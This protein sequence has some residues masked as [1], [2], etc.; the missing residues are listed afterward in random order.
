[1]MLDVNQLIYLFF[2]LA[3][4]YGWFILVSPEKPIIYATHFT[5]PLLMYSFYLLSQGKI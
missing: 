4:L 1:M 3:P 2:G 5:F